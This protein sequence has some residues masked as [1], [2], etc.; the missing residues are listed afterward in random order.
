MEFRKLVLM[1]QFAG[2]EI[3]TQTQRA[4]LWTQ[5]GKGRV[6]RVSGTETYIMHCCM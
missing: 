5:Q 4:D 1:N 6:G 3:E 2:A